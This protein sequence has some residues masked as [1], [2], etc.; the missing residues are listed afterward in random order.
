MASE[1]VY[2]C[3]DRSICFIIMCNSF[4]CTISCSYNHNIIYLKSVNLM[5][6]NLC[7]VKTIIYYLWNKCSIKC[8]FLQCKGGIQML[9]SI[10]VIKKAL[11]HFWLSARR[12][13]SQNTL[14]LVLSKQ[15]HRF[16]NV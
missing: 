3:H 16:H 7:R 2:F 4:E 10:E 5:L 13:Q 12:I 6:L 9:Y 8:I 15:K 14:S 11:L 1:Q